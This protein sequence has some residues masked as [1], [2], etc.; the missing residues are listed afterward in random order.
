METGNSLTS[1]FQ[2]ALAGQFVLERELGRGGMGIVYL[3]RDVRLDRLVAIKV[4]PPDLA[5]DTEMR[6]RFLREARTAGQLAHP[7]IVPV[8]RADEANGFA[9]FVMAYIDGESLGER[10]RARGP[11]APQEAIRVLREAAWA[12]AYAHKSGT[13]HRDIKPENILI[14]RATGRALVTDFGI[15]RRESNPHLTHDGQVLGTVFY[16]SPEQV[17]GLPLDGRSD[18]YSLGVVGFYVLSG[19]L[20]FA[21]DVPSAVLLAHVNRPAP[22]L[23]SVARDIPPALA[24]VI[25]RCLLK[26]REARYADGEALADALGRA[27]AAAPPALTPPAGVPQVL[28]E[29]Q[30]QA[31]WRRA[32]ELQAEATQRL[33]IRLRED[34]ERLGPTPTEPEGYRTSVVEAAAVEAGISPEYVAI[35]MAELKTDRPAA[36]AELTPYQER[37][38]T[39]LLNLTEKSLRVTRVIRSSPRVVLAAI[40]RTLQGYPYELRLKDTIGGHPLYGGVLVF[41]VGSWSEMA[42][43]AAGDQVIHFKYYL[44]ASKVAQLKVTLH[45]FTGDPDSCEVVVHVDLRPGIRS[46]VTWAAPVIG[47]GVV[48]GGAGAFALGVGA[49]G[50]GPLLAVLPA[51]GGAALLGAASFGFYRLAGKWGFRK[52]REQLEKML[53]AVETAARS[54]ELFGVAPEP[55]RRHGGR[56]SGDGGFLATIA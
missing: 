11:M 40:G 39:E 56:G 30:A 8:Y 48:G 22:P 17:E 37:V 41:E 45:P 21:G 28:S 20:P 5:R 3:A 10:V 24:Q 51:L 50:L 29:P 38:A 19:Q 9:W 32:A 13:V 44:A 27:A 43:A 7:N 15:A 2:A 34:G 6:E 55:S 23:A 26:D 1:A 16:M 4:L 35:A 12:L 54:Q 53:G 52:A 25:D 33:Q 46:A 18:L 14:E 47:S 42:T 49:L 36:S 31:I